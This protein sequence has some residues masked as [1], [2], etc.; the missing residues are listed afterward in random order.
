MSIAVLACTYYALSLPPPDLSQLQLNGR[1]RRDITPVLPQCDARGCVRCTVGDAPWLT[2]VSEDLTLLHATHLPA[3]VVLPAT[4]PGPDRIFN[5]QTANAT[6][7]AAQTLA[8]NERHTWLVNGC[9]GS[10]VT[11]TAAQPLVALRTTGAPT[12]TLQHVPTQTPNGQPVAALTLWSP[13]WYTT[14]IAYYI[15]NDQPLCYEPAVPFYWY[16]RADNEQY[17]VTLDPLLPIVPGSSPLREI[18]LQRHA[19]LVSTAFLPPL[20]REDSDTAVVFSCNETDVRWRTSNDDLPALIVGPGSGDAVIRV[21]GALAFNTPYPASVLYHDAGNAT[22]YRGCDSESIA[23]TPFRGVEPS[24]LPA[25]ALYSTSDECELWALPSQHLAP[26]VYASPTVPALLAF[27]TEP[28]HSGRRVVQLRPAPYWYCAA[29][30]TQWLVADQAEPVTHLA[31]VRVENTTDTPPITTQMLPDWVLDGD[32]LPE[33]LV[34]TGAAAVVVDRRETLAVR[35]RNTRIF[36][37]AAAS[38]PRYDEDSTL[39]RVYTGCEN[40]TVTTSPW[41][42]RGDTVIELLPPQT[43]HVF[44]NA[45]CDIGVLTGQHYALHMATPGYEFDL[46]PLTDPYQPHPRSVHLGLVT[47]DAIVYGPGQIVSFRSVQTDAHYDTLFMPTE[48]CTPGASLHVPLSRPLLARFP[49]WDA[50]A[51][52]HYTNANGNARIV[53]PCNDIAAT[54]IAATLL[55]TSWPKNA[56]LTTAPIPAFGPYPEPIWG[57]INVDAEEEDDS[58]GIVVFAGQTVRIQKTFYGTCNYTYIPAAAAPEATPLGIA[59]ITYFLNG[60]ATTTSRDN[61]GFDRV[62]VVMEA[63]SMPDYSRG[64]LVVDCAPYAPKPVPNVTVDIFVDAKNRST[65]ET[66]HTARYGCFVPSCRRYTGISYLTWNV[67]I[68]AYIDAGDE[69]TTGLYEMVA[70]PD[71]GSQRLLPDAASTLVQA[72]YALSFETHVLELCVS[73]LPI[74]I[75]NTTTR[76][77]PAFITACKAERQPLVLSNRGNATQALTYVL[78]EVTAAHVAHG[79]PR[80]RDSS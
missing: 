12:T 34:A 46:E 55:G 63:F 58:F 9:A 76:T 13:P 72:Q 69:R 26:T 56:S 1:P 37:V 18:R 62:D 5:L 50:T 54:D 41:R 40:T 10:T 32:P 11:V 78:D 57:V 17:P 31:L 68:S 65:L 15:E 42:G 66:T 39:P 20:V 77:R 14:N 79:G 4:S 45:T 28:Y 30:G 25:L 38:L 80:R 75:D 52:P 73:R 7:L 35:V 6:S 8:P 43:V 19:T 21:Q 49:A 44:Q 33:Q 2:Y 23:L 60:S 51:S 47:E 53:V 61:D 36:D 24:L 48:L 29:N 67:T 16:V 59:N 74:Y 3:D 70:S 71:Y 22:E 64:T 27:V